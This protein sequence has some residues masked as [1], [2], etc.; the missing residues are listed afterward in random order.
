MF[1][2]HLTDTLGTCFE[3]TYGRDPG[4]VT[5]Q[6]GGVRCEGH[7]R[8]G[9]GEDGRRVPPEI[10]RPLSGSGYHLFPYQLKG[11]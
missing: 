8:A 2:K 4:S 6:G 9:G 1:L 3:N 5:A 7:A 11:F 10:N